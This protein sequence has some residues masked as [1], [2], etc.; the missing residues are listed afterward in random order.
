VALVV[1]VGAITWVAVA[2]NDDDGGSSA[3]TV[4]QA[5]VRD[6][7]PQVGDR[8]PDFTATTL[9]GKKVSLSDYAGKPVILNFWASW[10]NP[11]REE[12]PLFREELARHEGDFVML[13]VDNRDIESDA[14]KFAR[15]QRADW[16]IASDSSNAVYKAYGAV[17]LPQT[18]FIKPDG[19]IA[20][21]YYQAI[22]D[23]AEFR[24]GLAKIT[25]SSST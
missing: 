20:V 25:R 1:V 6:G 8:A 24:K 7:G 19:T 13:G 21:R 15:E 14:R 2:G 4:Q 16:P 10:C 9:D 17:G 5:D 12:F 18:F 11:C 3:S 22:P 23:A